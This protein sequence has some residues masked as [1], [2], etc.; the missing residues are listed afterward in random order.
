MF[1]AKGGLHGFGGFHP[2]PFWVIASFVQLTYHQPG[3]I[4]RII[5]D[6]N[7]KQNI[8]FFISFVFHQ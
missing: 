8:H 5:N 1:P 4:I 2:F 7:A 3:V 6:Q